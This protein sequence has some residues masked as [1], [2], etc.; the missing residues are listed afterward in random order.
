[1]RLSLAFIY[2]GPAKIKISAEW[3][4]KK[5]ILVN[6]KFYWRQT[7]T[8]PELSDWLKEMKHVFCWADAMLLYIWPDSGQLSF[9]HVRATTFNSSKVCVWLLSI[10][11]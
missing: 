2:R 4:R 5:E 6:A 10:Q 1:V 9:N 7:L 3:T 8:G 11:R